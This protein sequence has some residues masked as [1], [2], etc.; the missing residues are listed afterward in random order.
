MTPAMWDVVAAGATWARERARVLQ[1]SRWVGGDAVELQVYGFG[2]WWEG[3]MTLLLRNPQNTSRP[4]ELSLAKA[5]ALPSALLDARYDVSCRFSNFDRDCQRLVVH[6]THTGRAQQC[7][8][9]Q[10]GLPCFSTGDGPRVHVCVLCVCVCCVVASP[11]HPHTHTHT[12][13]YT[14]T[15]THTGR[16]VGWR[17]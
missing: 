11:T 7:T 12:H 16:P 9:G 17:T 14:H 5:L 2:S 13:T 1:Q 8:E 6:G 15:H 4:V 10:G 3:D